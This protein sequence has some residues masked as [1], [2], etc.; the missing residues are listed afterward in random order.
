MQSADEQPPLLHI[1]NED[2]L[3]GL[4]AFSDLENAVIP[5]GTK[6]LPTPLGLLAQPQSISRNVELEPRHEKVDIHR[7]HRTKRIKANSR[8]PSAWKFIR[9]PTSRGPRLAQVVIPGNPPFRP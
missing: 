9:L 2:E 7:P 4:C 3:T 6:A 1:A 5:H 8:G